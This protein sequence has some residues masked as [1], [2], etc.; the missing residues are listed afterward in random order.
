MECKEVDD[1][2]ENPVDKHGIPDAK[3]VHFQNPDKDV[4]QTDPENPH[5][6]YGNYHGEGGFS[7]STEVIGNQKADGPDNHGDAVDADQSLSQVVCFRG[8]MIK[9]DPESVSDEHGAADGRKDGIVQEK[10]DSGVVF[11]LFFLPGTITLPHHSQGG[12]PQCI[13]RKIQVGNQVGGNRIAGNGGCAKGGN[14]TL[15]RQLPQLKDSAFHTAGN[16]DGQDSFQN[17][18][19]RNKIPEVMHTCSCILFL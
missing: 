17:K 10:H 13:A 15:Q 19:I 7:N 9:T 5:G 6:K 3:N 4:G 14:Q 12:S 8:Q 18:S 11:C 2:S 1:G 16:A